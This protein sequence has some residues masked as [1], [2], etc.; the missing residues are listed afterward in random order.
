MNTVGK[1]SWLKSSVDSFCVTLPT[2]LNLSY[3]WNFGSLLGLCL[4]MQI[5]SGLFLSFHY[6][7]HESVAFSSVVHIDRDVNMGWLLHSLHANGASAFFFCIYAHIGRGLYY[8][9][10]LQSKVWLS[11]VAIYLVSM[12]VAFLGYVL[13]WGQMSF[14]GA[15]VITNL[16]TAIPVVGEPL[17]YWIWGGFSVSG[18]T[19][20]RFYS[21]HFILP[22]LLVMMV[23]VHLIF[24][25][26]RGS[27]NPLGVSSSTAKIRF[28]PYYTSK[29]ILGGVVFMSMFLGLC[30]LKPHLLGAPDNFFPANTLSTPAH[31][32]PEWYFLYAY[33]IL[34]SMPSKSLG[35]LYMGFSIVS[36]CCFSSYHSGIF[37]SNFW[38]PPMKLLFWVLLIT[39]AMLTWL[40][41]KPAEAPFI[42]WGQFFSVVYLLYYPLTLLKVYWEKLVQGPIH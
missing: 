12:G 15:T 33:T 29:D 19:L 32:Q 26:E 36:L 27:S 1:N 39:L 28:H 20:T 25:H 4:M 37:Q 31:I 2:P 38:A 35:V 13:P 23:M 34:R 16:L 17:V 24:L 3:W 5:M 6:G 22:F 21:L 42:M 18:A 41:S 7:A 40:G 14:W 8:G 30:L 9:C 11:G 10:Y